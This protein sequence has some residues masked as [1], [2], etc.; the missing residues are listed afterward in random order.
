MEQKSGHYDRLGLM[1]LLSFVAMY[2]LMYAMVDRLDHVFMNINKVY[3]A[4][5]MT[6]PMVAIEL[7]LMG[8]MYSSRK[9]N[10]ALIVASVAGVV[11]FWVLIRGQGAVADGQFLRSM[12]PH[13]SSAILMC[14]EASLS[15]PGIE[16]LC[17]RIIA[18]QESEIGEM[19]EK[20]G[21]L[22]G[23]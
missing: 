5:L 6:A 10:A 16:D 13:H 14:R 17:R 9:L 2:V 11:L 15:D 21:K 12:I 22:A 20:L 4:A 8:S 7:V 19:K 23:R 1:V 3:M 18:N